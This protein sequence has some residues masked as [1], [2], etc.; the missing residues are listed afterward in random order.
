[1]SDLSY[2]FIY[3]C[4]ACGSKTEVTRADAQELHTNPENLEAPEKVLQRRGWM[5]RPIGRT[6]C[7]KCM[8]PEMK[9]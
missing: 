8:P 2:P 9:D 5:Q 7:P 3:Q 1:M 6:Y 4:N